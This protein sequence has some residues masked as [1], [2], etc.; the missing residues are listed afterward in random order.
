M[1]CVSIFAFV[2]KEGIISEMS[3][4]VDEMAVIDRKKQKIVLDLIHD[5][6]VHHEE[7]VYSFENKN[8]YK[9]N[10]DLL[11]ALGLAFMCAK[12]PKESDTSQEMIEVISNDGK[13]NNININKDI[14]F[15][16]H[17]ALN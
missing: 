17:N 3:K 14:G 12:N 10:I 7:D 2:D 6:H 8:K 4:Y 5:T 13:I 11:K 9:E 16:F 1:S 15:H